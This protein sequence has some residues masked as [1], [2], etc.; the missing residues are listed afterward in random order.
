MRSSGSKVGIGLN[1]D[2]FSSFLDLMKTVEV[3]CFGEEPSGLPSGDPEGILSSEGSEYVETFLPC[4]VQLWL[5][6]EDFCGLT[7]LL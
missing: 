3:L 6:V 1:P 7:A 2:G 4:G 5:G